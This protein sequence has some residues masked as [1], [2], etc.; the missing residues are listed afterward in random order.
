MADSEKRQ[1]QAEEAHERNRAI[2]SELKTLIKKADAAIEAGDSVLA[3]KNL[4]IAL[5]KLDIAASKGV[6][7][8]NQAANRKSALA[9]RA[10]TVLGVVSDD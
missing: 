3:A 1:R 8:P 9:Q 5:R 4:R 2:K 7:H 10:N 6:I